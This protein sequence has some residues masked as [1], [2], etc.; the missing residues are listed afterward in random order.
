MALPSSMG[1]TEG[2]IMDTAPVVVGVD[3]SPDSV[4]ALR[5][6]HDYAEQ[7][8]APLRVVTAYT[9]PPN[10]G[11]LY[12]M[13]ALTDP[14]RMAED[15]RRVLTDT[16][17]EA[18]GSGSTVAAH[19]EEGHPARVLVTA[20]EGAAMLVVGSRGHGGFVG[21]M[22]GSVSQYCVTHATCPVVVLPHE[23]KHS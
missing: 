19:T 18:L 5:W 1:P 17:H 12:G 10:Y 22:L 6:A 11:G 15:A 4:R 14:D 7:I 3:G 23:R 20:A 16:V 8:G 13:G 9:Q 2:I 21:L